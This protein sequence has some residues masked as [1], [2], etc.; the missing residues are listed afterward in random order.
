MQLIVWPERIE[1]CRVAFS[2][3]QKMDA[4]MHT[5]KKYCP[6]S[7]HDSL[8]SV[9]TEWASQSDTIPV[10]QY[11]ST[12]MDLHLPKEKNAAERFCYILIFA[13]MPFAF[14]Y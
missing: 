10:C 9:G 4:G 8:H 11:A 12:L 5:T 1:H 7:P 3:F 13:A 6:V 2:R 14:I